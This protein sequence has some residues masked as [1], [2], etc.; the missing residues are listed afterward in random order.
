MCVTCEFHRLEE[1]DMH[2][3]LRSLL[4]L[5]AILWGLAG[6][7]PTATAASTTPAAVIGDIV[8]ELRFKDIRGLVRSSRELG[9]HPATVLVF[10]TSDC[11]LVQRVM[12]KLVALERAHREAGVQFVAVNVGASDTLKDMAAQAIEF[13]AP[14]AFVKDEEL[15]CAQRLGIERTP[16]AA[17]FDSQWRLVYR[18]RID[19]QDRL[20]GTKPEPS[21]HDLA[22]AIEEVLAGE[23]VT[24]ST[25]PV[26]GCLITS[27]PPPQPAGSPPTY[28]HD[29]APLLARRCTGCH[30]EGTAA[31][32]TLL[33][34]EDATAHAEMI[35]EVVRDERMPP[36]SAHPDY[37]TFQNDPSLSSDE[38]QVLFDWIAAGR[39][40]GP[41]P[42][43]TPPA[44]TAAP[45]W[46][47][48]TPD[49]VV[50]MANEQDVQA[51]GYI[52][53]QYVMLPHVFLQETWLEAIEIKPHNPEV[54]HHCNLAYVTT[55]G[56]SAETFITGHV[57]GG[58]P[59]DLGH[60][61]EQVAYRVPAFAGLILQIHYTTTGK[62]EKSRISVGFRFPKNEITKRLHHVLLDPRDLAIPPGDGGHAVRSETTLA[63]NANLLGMFTHMHLRGKDMTFYAEPPGERRHPLLMIPTFS[64][65]WQLGYEC[66]PGSV[67]LPKGTTLSAVAHYD[68]SAFN[69]YNP[70][71][72]RTVP[73]GA[74]SYD[75][76]FNGYIFYTD[77][78]EA[79]ALK[80]D[81]KTGVVSR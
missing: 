69:P 77:I 37:G 36:W 67:E 66:A 3:T 32:F 2:R 52:P 20:G 76:M 18:G 75:E 27:P 10:V 17:V 72:T 48:G 8:D 28:H 61:A 7:G 47:I 9:S 53:Y 43:E 57:P 19:D 45:D 40:A 78:D 62:P 31:P 34:Y 11:P 30:R 50:T 65:D 55:A 26:D 70:D 24:V 16:E 79:L 58:Q 23:P 13:E 80:V 73:Y 59:L 44:P 38:K 21:R 63:H 51:T 56:A 14:F 33:S 12:P 42:S 15:S 25:T 22:L 60:F 1:D 29:I 46:R 35:G 71:P 4:I 81:P 68:N 41:P 74:Q 5:T 64:F 6:N 54:V 39:P 49:L